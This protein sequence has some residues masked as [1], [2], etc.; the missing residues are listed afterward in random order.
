MS[1]AIRSRMLKET[2]KRLQGVKAGVFVDFK[3]LDAK[4]ATALRRELRASM[5]EMDVLKNSIAVRAFKELGLAGLEKTFA[6]MVALVHGPD[7]G[8]IARKLMAWKAKNK[9]LELKAAVIENQI[10]SAKEVAE[11]MVAIPDRRTA[12]AKIAGLMQAPASSFVNGL[13]A[14]PQ[15]MALLL[16]AL[17]DKKKKAEGAAAPATA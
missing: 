7:P 10:L 11:D 13:N 4:L 15:K 5:I 6:G 17:E 14:L 1:K 16:A 9:K 8:D 12:L 2:T 3:G